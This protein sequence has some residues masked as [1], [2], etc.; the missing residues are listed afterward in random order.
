RFALVL[1]GVKNLVRDAGFL[2]QI[3]D[4]FGF[5]DGDGADEDGLAAFVIMADTVGQGIVLLKNAVD[6][7]FDLFFFGA[8]D[9]VAMLLANQIAVGGNPHN[10]EIVD[11]G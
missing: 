3:A 1:L 8:V 6:D 10:I 2:K 9:D 11:F 5:L 7:G 4:G